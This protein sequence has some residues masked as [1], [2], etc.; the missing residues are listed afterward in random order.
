M[1]LTSIWGFFP[2][3][4]PQP[5]VFRIFSNFYKNILKSN[6]KKIPK[7][8]VA[9]LDNM[10]VNSEKT[11]CIC[12]NRKEKHKIPKLS[13]S[14]SPDICIK[15]IWNHCIHQ[16]ANGQTANVLSLTQY[17]KELKIAMKIP[18]Q[19]L[20]FFFFFFNSKC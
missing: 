6:A 10:N 12:F 19:M 4:I 3:V 14:F 16:K 5:F 1:F 20:S 11:F 15:I 9:N 2:P 13:Y 18:Y 17:W 7:Y 8:S